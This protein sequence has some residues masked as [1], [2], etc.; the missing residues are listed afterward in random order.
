MSKLHYS[1]G[2]YFL[3]EGEQVKLLLD[4]RTS[5]VNKSRVPSHEF[6]Q[7]GGVEYPLSTIVSGATKKIF[8]KTSVSMAELVTYLLIVARLLRKPQVHTVLRIGQ[9]SPL[10]E[11]LAQILPQF[12][13][14]N[15]LY[16]LS[17]TRPLGR[18]PSVNF[19][20]AEGEEYLLPEDKF[21]TIIFPADKPPLEVLLALKGHGK[22][23]FA[24]QPQNVEELLRSQAKIFPLTKQAALFELEVSP[25]LRYE[26]RLLT[27]QGQLD[28]KKAEI[29]QIVAQMPSVLKEKNSRLDEYISEVVRAEKLLAEIFP[30][31]HSETIK[32]NFNLLKEFLIDLRLGNGSVARLS[33]QYEVLVQDLTNS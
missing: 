11:A 28:E 32:F 26:L 19:L 14:A 5:L 15:K 30:E 29:A 20:F 13:P 2:K 4:V 23:Y 16:C 8:K 25:H 22:I 33:R 6:N 24:T 1:K 31:L 3:R 10:D 17:E 21:D 27:P 7:Q 18:I 9:W 12:N